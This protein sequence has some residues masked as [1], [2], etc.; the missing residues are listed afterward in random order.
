MLLITHIIIALTSLVIAT[1]LIFRPIQRLIDV[2]VG[3]I[4]LTLATGTYLTILSPA[5]L[6]STCATG[7]VY[8]VFVTT[9]TLYARRSLALARQDT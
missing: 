6:I 3:L 8:T 1:T 5:H 4:L 9:A 7:I 2:N